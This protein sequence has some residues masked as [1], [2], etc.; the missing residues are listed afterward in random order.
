M[1]SEFIRLLY[2]YNGITVVYMIA[3]IHGSYV[4]LPIY[5]LILLLVQPSMSIPRHIYSAT[6]D[7]FPSIVT[8]ENLEW[9]RTSVASNLASGRAAHGDRLA[10]S[11]VFRTYLLAQGVILPILQPCLSHD[12]QRTIQQPFAFEMFIIPALSVLPKF[13]QN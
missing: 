2:S 5:I 12:T 11:F 6:R 1:L 13:T 7:P 9:I 10:E 8:A 4:T 3:K